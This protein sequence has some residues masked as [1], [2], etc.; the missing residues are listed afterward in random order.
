[1]ADTA[2]S[3]TT[4]EGDRSLSFNVEQVA[5]H[6]VHVQVRQPLAIG[7]RPCEDRHRVTGLDQ[8]FDDGHTESPGTPEHQRWITIICEDHRERKNSRQENH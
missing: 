2:E 6:V 5:D 8:S 7:G 3:A 4:A 1:M